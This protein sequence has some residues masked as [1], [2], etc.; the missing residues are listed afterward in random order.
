MTIT[1]I[2]VEASSAAVSSSS[3]DST[4]A[5]PAPAGVAAAPTPLKQRTAAFNGSLGFYTL[6][7]S[8]DV[9]GDFFLQRWAGNL[10]ELPLAVACQALS[11]SDMPW[12][13]ARLAVND[14][15]SRVTLNA[16]CQHQ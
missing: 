4:Q 1:G 7:L 11:A 6:G 2:K 8:I 5:A 16:E 9:L 12:W 15:H 10:T 14:L 3:S 13:H